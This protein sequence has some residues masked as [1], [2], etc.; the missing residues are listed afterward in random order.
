MRRRPGKSYTID[1][2][3]RSLL[4]AIARQLVADWLNECAETPRPAGRIES[5]PCELL[6]EP[7]GERAVAEESSMKKE[8]RWRGENDC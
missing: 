3:L 2:R 6:A 5:S 1:S 7:D 4:D 8:T